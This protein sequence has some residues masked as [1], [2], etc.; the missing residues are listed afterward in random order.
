MKGIL[1]FNQSGVIEKVFS[2]LLL[3][4]AEFHNKGMFGLQ[5]E[6]SNA[7]RRVNISSRKIRS[8]LSSRNDLENGGFFGSLK[9]LKSST[10]SGPLPIHCRPSSQSLRNCPHRFIP[11]GKVT[12]GVMLSSK[13][14][15]AASAVKKQSLVFD[16]VLEN[17]T[18]S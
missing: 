8:L 11:A 14:S 5:E 3:H 18:T 17:R 4:D 7:G 9:T 6:C 16:E 10:E 12:E 1:I 2:L 15:A 13:W